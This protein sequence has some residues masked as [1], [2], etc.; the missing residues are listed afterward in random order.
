MAG[1][2]QT[3]TEEN[4]ELKQRIA[5]AVIYCNEKIKYLSSSKFTSFWESNYVNATEARD[6]FLTLKNKL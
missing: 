5:D 4:E 3:L 6:M 2:I 1:K